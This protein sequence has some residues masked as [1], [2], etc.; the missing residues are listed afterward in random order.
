MDTIKKQCIQHIE[1]YISSGGRITEKQEFDLNLITSFCRNKKLTVAKAI[2]MHEL[3]CTINSAT[4]QAQILCA[5]EGLLQDSDVIRGE[6]FTSRAK[7]CLETCLHLAQ[8]PLKRD[9]PDKQI[10]NFN[11]S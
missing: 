11:G 9:E 10:N 3:K 8:T 4:T 6:R 7:L 1:K 5:I 2:K